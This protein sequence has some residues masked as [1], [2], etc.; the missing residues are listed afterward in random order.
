MCILSRFLVCLK[1]FN[2]FKRLVTNMQNHEQGVLEEDVGA[3]ERTLD[4]AQASCLVPSWEATTC[5]DVRVAG[6]PEVHQCG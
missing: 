6:H 2:L 4:G 3:S 5:M 1:L